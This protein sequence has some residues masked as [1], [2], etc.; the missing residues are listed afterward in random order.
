MVAICGA[1]LIGLSLF[2]TITASAVLFGLTS[3]WYSK[4][5]R[6]KDEILHSDS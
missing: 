1:D 6:K 2:G 4:A 5:K 3:M